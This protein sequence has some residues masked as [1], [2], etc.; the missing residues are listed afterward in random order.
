[1]YVISRVI[2]A[3]V[4]LWRPFIRYF[5]S[6]SGFADRPYGFPRIRCMYVIP[7]S[8]LFRQPARDGPALL[9]VIYPTGAPL[10]LVSC[11]SVY[12]YARTHAFY[13]LLT[14]FLISTCLPTISIYFFVYLPHFMVHIAVFYTQI[15]ARLRYISIFMHRVVHKNLI[16]YYMKFRSFLLR[17]T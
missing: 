10:F 15:P 1:M 6:C 16:S 17:L 13:H 14:L 8:L 7:F 11:L 2:Y 3:V 9:A 5:L 4:G 12:Y